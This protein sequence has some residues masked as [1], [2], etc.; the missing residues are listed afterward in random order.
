MAID[1]GAALRRGADDIASA[2]GVVI[3]LVF[4]AFTLA[5]LPIHQTL[6]R[7]M[8]EWL[9]DVAGLTAED[10]G[11]P[12]T[13]LALD[14]NLLVVGAALVAIFLIAEAIRLVA[15]RSF[16]SD[17]PSTIPTDEV[18]EG[19]RRTYGVLLL[20]SIVVQVLVY[21]GMVVF[22]IPGL[23]AGVLTLFVRQAVVLDGEGVLES[24][25][26]SISIVTTETAQTLALLVALIVLSMV[27]GA[28]TL[29]LAPESVTAPLLGAVLGTIT[30]VYGVAVL[31]RAYQQAD[32]DAE[33][34]GE[35]LGPD[36]LENG[37][38]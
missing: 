23:I 38:V 32:T 15:I 35:A 2:R 31:T 13:P 21:G 30:T 36:D 10:V 17:S 7:E 3:Y 11:M 6:N 28:P 25:K 16:A 18:G 9:A 19:W 4:A 29:V 37:A 26:T 24:I 14:V 1:A 33:E 27:A 20:A 5:S 22:I 8:T 34:T 12:A